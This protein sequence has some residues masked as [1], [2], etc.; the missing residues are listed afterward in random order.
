MKMP[1]KI[2]LI[3]EKAFFLSES[4]NPNFK[5][6]IYL[7]IPILGKKNNFFFVFYKKKYFSL[8]EK[9]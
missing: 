9:K 1:V 5:R 4:N 6:T 2:N 3:E 8:N 7:K